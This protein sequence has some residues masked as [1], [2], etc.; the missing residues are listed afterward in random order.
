MNPREAEAALMDKIR[1]GKPVTA[2]DH[3][4]TI[5]TFAELDAFQFGLRQVDRLTP[6]LI[7]LI[8]R[9]RRTLTA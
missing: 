6:E 9:H 4:P 5:T 8:I 7:G 3:I 1:S 2:E